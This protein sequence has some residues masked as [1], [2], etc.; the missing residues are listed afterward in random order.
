MMFQTHPH[1]VGDSA[2]MDSSV[3]IR[4]SANT[5][6]KRSNIPWATDNVDQQIQ[7]F[8]ATHQTQQMTSRGG[9]RGQGTQEMN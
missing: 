1:T 6:L 3:E 5:Q 7:S 4:P 9:G 2:V 8:N